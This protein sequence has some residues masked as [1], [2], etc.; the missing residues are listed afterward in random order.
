VKSDVPESKRPTR[1]KKKER[2]APIPETIEEAVVFSVAADVPDRLA[3]LISRDDDRGDDMSSSD[4]ITKVIAADDDLD[5]DFKWL[6]KPTSG[7]A[8]RKRGGRKQDS[9]IAKNPRRRG[10]GGHDVAE[11]R[12]IG[13]PWT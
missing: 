7:R 8:S 6:D 11:S 1:R 9:D 5:P 13:I 10:E 3:E 4:I 2:A 12:G